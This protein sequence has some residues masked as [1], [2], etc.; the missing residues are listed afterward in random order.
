MAIYTYRCPE[1]GH[2]EDVFH[3]M[4]E[5]DRANMKPETV[6]ETTCDPNA[7]HAEPVEMVRHYGSVAEVPRFANASLPER[8]QMMVKRSQE[9]YKK[10]GRE[11]KHEQTKAFSRDVTRRFSS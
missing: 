7:V 2:T 10:D 1:C 6:T 4:A 11:M 9:H 3:T 8:Q 5:T